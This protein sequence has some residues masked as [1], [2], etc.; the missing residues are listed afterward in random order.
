MRLIAAF[1]AYNGN[2]DEENDDAEMSAAGCLSTIKKILGS[3]LSQEAYHKAFELMIPVFNYTLSEKG[4]DY[5]DDALGCLNTFLFYMDELSE[6]IWHYFL[7]L[8]YI[9]AGKPQNIPL[10]FDPSTLPEEKRLILEQSESGWGSEYVEHML[11]ALQNYV[12]KGKGLL[13]QAKDPGYGLTYLE[14][15]FK[16]I[17]RIYEINMTAEDDNDMTLITT[18][19]ICLIENCT[20]I[21]DNIV[22][23]IIEKCIVLLENALPKQTNFKKIL[24]QTVPTYISSIMYINHYNKKTRLRWEFGIAPSLPSPIS[25]RKVKRRSCLRTSWKPY[26]S[27]KMISKRKE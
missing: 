1:E 7:V 17:E 14:L 19:F 12:K 6:K 9:M 16:T 25:S 22:P 11:G 10:D 5:I 8:N 15:L 23:L 3:K 26:Q 4:C 13:L 20:G 27:L 21:L 18:L 24:T 2:D